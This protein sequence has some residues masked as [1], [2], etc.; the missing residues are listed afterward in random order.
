MSEKPIRYADC[1]DPPTGFQRDHAR[2]SGLYNEGD[3]VLIWINEGDLCDLMLEGRARH[4][5]LP[6]L[7]RNT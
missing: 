7:P 6:T 4:F 1:G 3:C 5:P 2:S